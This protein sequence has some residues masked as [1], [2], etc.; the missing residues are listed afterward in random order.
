MNTETNTETVTTET[1]TETVNTETNTETVNTETNTEPLN[2]ELTDIKVD[3]NA[4][5]QF[6]EKRIN[7]IC[8]LNMIGLILI[9][10]TFIA[11][12]LRPILYELEISSASWFFGALVGAITGWIE[13]IFLNGF[14]CLVKNTKETR[15]FVASIDQKLGN[16]D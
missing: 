7:I 6:T 4:L 16:K 13:G 2:I 1:N 14:A 3:T 11:N 5:F 12:I 10:A 9:G 15:D 8:T